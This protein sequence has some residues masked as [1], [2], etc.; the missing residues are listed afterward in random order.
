MHPF[1]FNGTMLNGTTWHWVLK[2]PAGTICIIADVYN[3]DDNFA[4]KFYIEFTYFHS[5]RRVRQFLSVQLN[6]WFQT[7]LGNNDVY[8]D[9]TFNL[10]KIIT[11]FS[12]ELNSKNQ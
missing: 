2:V 12:S 3:D 7:Q 1:Y 9:F 5:S 4:V 8:C 6:N 10:M 11:L